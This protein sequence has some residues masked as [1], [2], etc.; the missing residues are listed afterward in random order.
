MEEFFVLSQG[1]KHLRS[2]LGMPHVSE[3]RHSCKPEDFSNLGWQVILSKRLEGVIVKLLGVSL[4]VEPNVGRRIEVTSVVS[5][6]HI[7]TSSDQ[8]HG[9][10]NIWFVVDPHVCLR[11]ETM[12]KEDNLRTHWCR[13]QLNSEHPEHVPILSGHPVLFVLEAL[14][15]DQLLKGHL[16]LL[17]DDFIIT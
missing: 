16:G 3:L 4:L 15:F 17:E 9:H 6:P 14:S 8:L 2:S 1:I 7:V 13:R 5:V 12:L 11:H 10:R